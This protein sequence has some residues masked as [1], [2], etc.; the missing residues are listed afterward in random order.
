MTDIVLHLRRDQVGPLSAAQVDENMETLGSR[1]NTAFDVLDGMLPKTDLTSAVTGVS[2]KKYGAVGNGIADDTAAIRNGISDLSVAGG[3]TLF[4]PS[5]VYLV[6]P[7]SQIDLKSNVSLL[8]VNGSSIIKVKD[9]PG[10]YKTIFGNHGFSENV[11][12]VNIENLTFNQNIANNP[13]AMNNVSNPQCVVILT[14]FYNITVK[15]CVFNTCS[16]VNTL[17]FNGSGASKAKVSNCDFSFIA[18]NGVANYDNSC[19]YFDC[20]DIVVEFNHFSAVFPVTNT[21]YAMTAIETHGGPVV[22]AGNTITGYLNGINVCPNASVSDIAASIFGNVMRDVSTGINLWP[23]SPGLSGVVISNNVI[24]LSQYTWGISASNGITGSADAANT[25]TFSNIV[26][27]GNVIKF[28]YEGTT[29][30]ASVDASFNNGIGIYAAGTGTIRDIIVDSN[31]I[32]NAPI[33]GIQIGR[34][35]STLT[36]CR[37][38]NNTIINAGHH[39]I[40]A[41]DYRAYIGR[42]GSV[43]TNVSILNNTISDTS[44]PNIGCHAI[45]L[46]TQANQYI[47][48]K[49]SGNVENVAQGCLMIN[50]IDS[51]V[52]TDYRPSSVLYSTVFPPTSG[53]YVLGDIVYNTG[54]ITPGS[55]YVGYKVTIA[56]TAGTLAGVT[57]TINP[58]AKYEMTCNTVAGLSRGQVINPAGS[59]GAYAITRIFGNT[60][61]CAGAFPVAVTNAPVAFWAPTLKSFGLI[62]A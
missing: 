61:W 54:T 12:N 20:L 21:A 8:G 52:L 53:N 28:Q 27:Q 42:S 38:S 31:I 16:G 35:T 56:G 60:V 59:N 15:N 49:V 6:N 5:G 50:Q 45:I 18:R 29:Y 2:V 58:S 14:S 57:A 44:N 43:L 23:F 1:V 40:P 26:I 11:S 33:R 9:N 36:N 41:A 30:R 22:I 51:L 17:S 47:N 13:T 34:G 39:P 24:N 4:F 32:E 46:P 37:I 25:S 7:S 19:L 62:N 48:V 3:G 10:A 55:S